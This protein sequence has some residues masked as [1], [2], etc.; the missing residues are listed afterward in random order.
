VELKSKNLTFEPS[1]DGKGATQLIELITSGCQL[2]KKLTVIGK[3]S[4]TVRGF[5]NQNMF[6]RS[7]T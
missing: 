4:E 3:F 2:H 1:E 5:M 7:V 6:E